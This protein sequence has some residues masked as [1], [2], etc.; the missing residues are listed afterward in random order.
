MSSVEVVLFQ[1]LAGPKSEVKWSTVVRLRVDRRGDEGRTD[2]DE[3][4]EG[5]G[6]TGL[7]S[8]VVSCCF[9]FTRFRF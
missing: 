6:M 1:L 3:D 9:H 8:E 2:G 7:S 4:A 5:V